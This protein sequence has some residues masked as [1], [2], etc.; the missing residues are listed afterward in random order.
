M[1]LLSSHGITRD[2]MQMTHVPDGPWYYQQIRLGFNYRLTDIQ[3]AL[4]LSQLQRLDEYVSRRHS[5]AGNY[6]RMLQNLPVTTP[7]QHPDSYSGYHLM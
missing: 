2:P 7:W 1:A 5:I 4:G 3:A 6:N